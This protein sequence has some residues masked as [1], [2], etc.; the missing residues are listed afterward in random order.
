MSKMRRRR[1]GAG[2][3]QDRAIGLVLRVLFLHGNNRSDLTRHPMFLAIPCLP[4]SWV[5]VLESSYKSR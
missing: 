2:N 5:G 4:H 3:I 1:S